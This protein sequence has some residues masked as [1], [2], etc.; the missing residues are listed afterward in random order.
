MSL[1]AFTF[2]VLRHRLETITEEGA[3]A[4][5]RVSGS[6][7]ATEAFDLNTSIMSASGEVAFVGPYL[8]TGP[9]GQ[10]MIVRSIVADYADDPGFQP[11]DMFIC[12]DPYVGSVH[13][14]CVTL[15]GPIH[16]QGRLVAWT[17]ATLHV[18]DV[19]GPTAGQV[20]IGATSIFDEAP[21]IPPLRIVHGGRIARDVERAYLRRSR[22]PD[23]NAL[24]LRAKIAALNAIAQGI[25]TVIE[26]HGV[27]T[28]VAVIDETIERAT[29]HFRRRLAELPDG[30]TRQ[31][32][33]LD[34]ETAQ[35]GTAFLAVEL[36]VEK[37]GDRLLLDFEG[38]APQAPAVVNCT[39]SG[40]MSGVLVGL[41]TTLVWDAPWCPAA[42][43]HCIEVRSLPGTV[44]DAAWPAGCSMATMA[45]GFAATTATAIAIG[46]LLA[47]DPELRD[48]AMAAWAGAVGSVDVF[49]VDAG[50]RGFGTVLLD[51]MAS[52]T[53]ASARFDGIDSGGFLRSMACVVANV[54]HTESLFPL[55][56]LYRRQ[57]PDTG[58]PGRRR[59]GVGA[60]YAVMA[61]GVERI[62]MVSPHFSGSIEPESA[63]LVGGFP[64]ATNAAIVV[65][66]SGARAA[67]ASGRSIGGPE[68]VIGAGQALPG[69]ARIALDADDILEVI[70]TGGGGFG[71]PLEREAERVAGDVRARLVSATEAERAYGVVLSGEG[72]VDAGATEG[73]RA[74]LRAARLAGAGTALPVTT[75][76]ALT[77]PDGWH[78]LLVKGI[79]TLRCD[80]CRTEVVVRDP[81]EPLASL[82][83]LT[84]PLGAAGPH[85]GEGRPDPG[86]ELRQYC[87]PSCGRSV[88]VERARSEPV[89]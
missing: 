22:T 52:G 17:G 57:E 26:S 2:E 9:M 79:R 47:R 33:Y 3:L 59:G 67:M 69:V 42:I 61:H 14:N 80:R 78:D 34:R 72:E 55:L 88:H 43:E 19:G 36:R 7:L 76:V 58:G 11:G 49:G 73:R 50:G 44:V 10:G 35:N 53:G 24:D 25:E 30:S 68:D 37:L 86:F 48:R 56:Y 21:V 29:T 60:S 63:G 32:A 16:A 41:L 12:N 46:G 45:A 54:E 27:D 83:M 23:L 15:V 64:G 77:A 81:G 4:L 18:V 71:D 5:Q 82:P 75:P 28:F 38:S 31:V 40:L 1:D 62:A 65:R 89:R 8:L 74:R 85:T 6:P 84:L 13:Q 51:T 70:T 20:G 66:A 87:C 39:R